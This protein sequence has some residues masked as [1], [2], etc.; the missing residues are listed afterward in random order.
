MRSQN[1]DLLSL[2]EQEVFWRPFSITS[3]LLVQTAGSNTGEF[4]QIEIDLTF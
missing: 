3:N 2:A 1:S 4:G